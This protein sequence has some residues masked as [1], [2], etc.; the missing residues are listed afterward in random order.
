MHFTLNLLKNKKPFFFLSTYV[1]SP[2]VVITAD[3]YELHEKGP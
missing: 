3:L 2:D 1:S